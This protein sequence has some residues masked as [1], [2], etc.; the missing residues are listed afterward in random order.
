MTVMRIA[1]LAACLGIAACAG[2]VDGATGSAQAD[3]P[4]CIDE[5]MQEFE[6]VA[7]DPPRENPEK[8]CWRDDP[9]GPPKFPA[10][11]HKI[12][13]EYQRGDYYAVQDSASWSFEEEPD[14]QRGCLV[15]K[16]IRTR[17]IERVEG[18]VKESAH[19]EEGETRR[20]VV[21]GEQYGSSIALGSPVIEV[22][23]APGLRISREST[24]HAIDC[25]R[26]VQT[27]MFNASICTFAQPRACQSTRVLMP[28]E[29][30]TP[31]TTGGTQVGSTTTLRVGAVTDKSS[32]ALP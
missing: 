14:L 22:A 30:R 20:S 24:R 19:V 4:G 27:N 5:F 2:E 15:A 11:S 23:E 21:T 31:N 7:D 28:A 3:P 13:I 25:I 6:A 8:M 12:R 18:G 32:W 10:L 17:V 26:T 29:I 9:E 16:M 1:C